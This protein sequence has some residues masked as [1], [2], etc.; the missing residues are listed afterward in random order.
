VRQRLISIATW[1]YLAGV[2]LYALGL[3][4]IGERWW[5]TTAALYLPHVALLAPAVPLVS[6]L[7]LVGRRQLVWVPMV[8]AVVVLFPIMGLV[9]LGG[10]EEPSGTPRLRVLSYNIDS[11][12]RSQ[13]Q[14]AAEIVGPRPDL[15]LLQEGDQQVGDAITALL[16]DHVRRAD[17]QFYIASRWPIVEVFNPPPLVLRGAERTPRFVRYTL[18]TPLGR[19]DVFNVHPVS[20]RDGFERDQTDLRRA[21]ATAVA[22]LARTSTNPVIIAGDTNLPSRSGIL[23][24]TLG[25]FQDGF[26]E[27]GRGFGYTFPAHTRFAWMRIDRI[28]ANR[29]LR[30]LSFDVGARHGSDHYA[31]WADLE[32]RR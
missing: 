22:A 9:V 1:A 25:Q 14:L 32:L 21:Q 10:A 24:D 3:G 16:P 13:P 6:L 8:A 23:A 29:K 26:D 2:V 7:A 17:G 15:V 28:F 19:L 11:G 30:F 31:V 18:D 20:P 12:R 27:V 5:L 4:L